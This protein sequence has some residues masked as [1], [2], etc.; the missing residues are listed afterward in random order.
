MLGT[1]SWQGL[2]LARTHLLLLIQQQLLAAC[3]R[4]ASCLL[5]CCQL[6]L[7]LN[8]APLQ[9]MHLLAGML[10]QRQAQDTGTSERYALLSLTLVFTLMQDRPAGKACRKALQDT[11]AGRLAQ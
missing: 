1:G 7:Q 10:L 8:K 9:H 4:L 3:I 6:R 11:R 2:P 5:C